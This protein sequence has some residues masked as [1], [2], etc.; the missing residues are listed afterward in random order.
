LQG[1]GGSGRGRRREDRLRRLVRRVRAG[2]DG[3]WECLWHELEPVVRAWVRDVVRSAEVDDVVQEVMVQTW[4]DLPH[5]REESQFTT[6][7]Y[8]IAAW[9]AYWARRKRAQQRVRLEGLAAT[10]PRDGAS[11]SSADMVRKTNLRDHIL[12]GLR[13]LG[14]DDRQVLAMRY[15]LDRDYAEIAALMS[16]SEAAVRQRCLRARRRLRKRLELDSEDDG[17]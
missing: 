7:V 16:E 13:R 17:A 4:K 9:R 10:M 11:R 3:S 12:A 14:P 1:Q 15:L 5:F 8:A 6:W 2:E